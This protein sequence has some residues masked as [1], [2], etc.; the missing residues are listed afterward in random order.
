MFKNPPGEMLHLNRC[1]LFSHLWRSPSAASQA[2]V[3]LITIPRAGFMAQDLSLYQ[4]AVKASFFHELFVRPLLYYAALVKNNYVVCFL[5]SAQS[6]RYDKHRVVLNI[7]I[8]GLLDLPRGN[9]EGGGLR[10]RSIQTLLC[11][12]SRQTHHTS[13]GQETICENKIGLAH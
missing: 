7:S 5:H 13:Q 12:I 10:G 8:N 4:L 6:V 1:A 9:W 11:S 2:A 3:Q